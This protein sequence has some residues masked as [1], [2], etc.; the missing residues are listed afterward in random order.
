MMM[1]DTVLAGSGLN[2]PFGR[3]V[4]AYACVC[5]CWRFS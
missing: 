1:S 2:L 5:R 3:G 4:L